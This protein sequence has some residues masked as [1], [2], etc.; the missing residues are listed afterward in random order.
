VGAMSLELAELKKISK[1]LML[2]NAEKLEIELA[3]Y[4]STTERKKAWILV[5][6]QRSP[7]ELIKGSG[8][9]QSALYNF[10]KLM[11][12]ADLIETPHGKAP[13]KKLDYIPASWLELL[14]SEPEN[15]KTEEKQ[16]VKTASN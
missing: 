7:E 15:K 2:A 4:A 12:S 3:K 13:T 14:Q 5:D 8:M 16:D 10:L 6:G 9:K 11:S 1:I